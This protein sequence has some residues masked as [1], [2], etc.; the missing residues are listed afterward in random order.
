[1]K[2][3]RFQSNSEL[4]NDFGVS[5]ETIRRRGKEAKKELF[6]KLSEAKVKVLKRSSLSTP[7]AFLRSCQK[8]NEQLGQALLL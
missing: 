1:M 8:W 6:P 3:R 5:R 7:R 2:R 4:A